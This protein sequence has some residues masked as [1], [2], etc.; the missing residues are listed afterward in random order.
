V[1]NNTQ[2]KAFDSEF[3]V[4]K[5]SSYSKSTVLEEYEKINWESFEKMSP[6]DM[7]DFIDLKISQIVEKVTPTVK[8]KSRS[9]RHL[10]NTKVNKLLANKQTLKRRY[11]RNPTNAL[12]E[13][14]KNINV[15]IKNELNESLNIKVRKS[16]KPGDSKTFWKSVNLI[17]HKGEYSQQAELKHENKSAKTNAEKAELFASFFESKI[18]KLREKTSINPCYNG[19]QNDVTPDLNFFEHSLIEQT[20]ANTKPSQCS[21]FDRIP[22]VYIKD[23]STVLSDKI[24]LLFNKVYEERKVPEQWK[25]GKITPIP[26]K[27]RSNE[28]SNYRPITSLCTLAKV[29]EK[30]I[31]TRIL[32]LGDFTGNNQHG[33]K[34]GHSTITAILQL[35]HDIAVSIDRGLYHG[36]ISLDLSA[37]FDMVNPGLLLERMKIAGLPNDVIEIIGDWLKDREAYVEFGGE[38][39][40]TFK[41]PEGTVQGSVLGPILFAIFVSPVFDL[42][43]IISFA[44]DSYL[45]ENSHNIDELLQS[46][47]IKA[48]MLTKWYKDS[49]LVVNENKT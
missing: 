4:R 32:G 2:K 46:L 49:G 7:C 45:S 6:Q 35:Q 14:I 41:V 3:F 25:I 11:R 39:S 37:A 23:L 44:D 16:I 21:G 29:F 38:S 8:V 18:E 36:V 13:K 33:F 40:M 47:S 17:R 26:K 10:W 12:C 48:N 1:G 20:L 22:M 42:F 24:V 19:K 28:V 34:K 15:T 9:C 43:N 27:G 5:W 31:L 30:C